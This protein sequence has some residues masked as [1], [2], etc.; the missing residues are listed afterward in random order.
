MHERANTADTEQILAGIGRD[1]HYALRQS[2]TM[3]DDHQTYRLRLILPARLRST[4]SKNWSTRLVAKS[5]LE[6]RSPLLLLGFHT[7][8]LV[9]E[10]S[11][12]YF[13]SLSTSGRS[14]RICPDGMMAFSF[15]SRMI[16]AVS[17]SS[18]L[19]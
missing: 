8:S 2:G 9:R 18:I 10:R 15:N 16:R 11:G 6:I 19:E 12:S 7:Y 13:S 5:L 14:R 1:L 4:R 3:M 17:S